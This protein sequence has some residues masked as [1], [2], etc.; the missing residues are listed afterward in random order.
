M[1]LGMLE[2]VKRCVF[3]GSIAFGLVGCAV[4][5][6]PMITSSAGSVGDMKTVS[7]IEGDA[8]QLGRMEFANELGAAFQQRGIAR[9]ENGDYIADFSVGAVGG[10]VWV[11]LDEGK[12]KDAAPLSLATETKSSIFD[13]CEKQRVR[14]SLALFERASGELVGKNDAQAI[15]C[16][17]AELPMKE[18]AELLV[19]DVL[20]N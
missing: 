1:E 13:K 15:I 12:E 19:S 7:V 9:A 6:A 20:S 2:K 10:Q 4:A 3:A 11:A 16:A 5:E 14:A 8:E 18:L 17:G